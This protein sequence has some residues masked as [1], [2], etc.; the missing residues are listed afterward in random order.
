MPGTNAGTGWPLTFRCSK[1][2]K[3][4]YAGGCA[5]IDAHYTRHSSHKHTPTGKTRPYKGGNRGIRGLRTFHQYTCECGHSGWSRH[6]DV[7]R[8]PVEQT[9]AD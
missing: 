2:R 7:Q 3:S 8:L 5:S 4:Q 6:R 1:C 9:E